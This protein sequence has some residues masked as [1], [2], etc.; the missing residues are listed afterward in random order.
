M[1]TDSNDTQRDMLLLACGALA[2][3]VI[4]IRDKYGWRADVYCAPALLHNTPD[5]IAP[6]VEQRILKLRAKYARV[7]VIYGECGTHNVLDVMLERLGVE[8]IA[9]PHCFEQYG[10]TVHDNLMET[11]PGTFFLTDFMVRSF[12]GLVWRSLGLDRFPELRDDYFA[13]YS[14]V[15]YLAQSEDSR[16]RECAVQAA[17]MLGLP[18]R[19]ELVGYG[20]LE[21]RLTRLVNRVSQ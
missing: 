12:N 11:I 3:D 13:N 5:R 8:R 18:L 9:G 14:Q 15:V 19:I 6:T 4:A 21:R 16:L 17:K 2:R 7:I 10:G 1:M 20:E